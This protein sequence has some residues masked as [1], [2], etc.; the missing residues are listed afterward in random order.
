MRRVSDAWAESFWSTSMNGSL[1]QGKIAIF[2]LRRYH[3]CVFQRW[4]D[5]MNKSP[6]A[7]CGFVHVGSESCVEERFDCSAVLRRVRQRV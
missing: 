7:R 1:S 4:Y 6:M 2:R 5:E 3:S